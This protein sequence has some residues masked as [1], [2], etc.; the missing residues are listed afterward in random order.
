MLEVE[1]IDDPAAATAA[2]APIRSRL[3]AELT[4]PASAAALAPRLGLTRQKVNY[5]LRSLEKHGLVEE[6][7]SRRWGGLTERLLV[8]TATAYVVSPGAMG[9]ASM[10]PGRHA[11]RLSAGYLIA[12]A[13]RLIREVSKLM[14]LSRK[15][16][17]RLP[18]LAIDTEIHFRS[19]TDRASFS[20]ELTRAVTDLAA[21]YHDAS[22]PDSRAHRVVVA[23]HPL[24]SDTHEEETS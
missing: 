15:A 18:T 14:R 13:A 17:R 22:H 21:R 16:G 3:L 4:E 5:H 12:L 9:P 19:A 2:M 6:A 8:A 24:A 11:D 23:G 20:A 7:G 1:V 10:D